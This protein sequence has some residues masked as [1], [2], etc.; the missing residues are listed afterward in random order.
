MFK[1]EKDGAV[2]YEIRIASAETGGEV[3]L[4]TSKTGF[5][6][7]LSLKKG[8]Y[9]ALSVHSLSDAPVDGEDKVAKILGEHSHQSHT[10]R[11]TRGDY[12]PLMQKMIDNLEKAKVLGCRRF[13]PW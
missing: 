1:S 12:A 2:S 13:L 4:L 6:G 10:I 9:F 3:F 8:K 5:E 11:V 7:D